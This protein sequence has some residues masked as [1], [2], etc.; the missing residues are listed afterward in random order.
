M[1]DKLV[2]ARPCGSMDIAIDKAGVTRHVCVGVSVSMSLG[3]WAGDLCGPSLSLCYV[4]LPKPSKASWTTKR[5]LRIDQDTHTHAHTHKNSFPQPVCLS[6]QTAALTAVLWCGY[7]AMFARVRLSLGNS[8]PSSVLSETG[9][10][11]SGQ[12]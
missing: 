10:L 3:L 6:K 12:R 7:S 2:A 5:R 4:N 9:H 11:V 8:K 1:W